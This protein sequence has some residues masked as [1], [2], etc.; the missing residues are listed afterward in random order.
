MESVS[1]PRQQAGFALII[2]LLLMAFLILL[3]VCMASLPR[4]ETQIA[5]NNQTAE[6]ARQTALFALNIALGHQQKA[7][8][9]DQ[10]IS[11]CSDV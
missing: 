1:H 3:V 8:G 4:V 10:P 7:A 5:L 11:R 9:P 2:T 6:K